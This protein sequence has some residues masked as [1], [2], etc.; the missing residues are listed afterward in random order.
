MLLKSK[1]VIIYVSVALFLSFGLAITGIAVLLHQG[2]NIHHFSWGS[3][4]FEDCHIVWDNKLRV[5]IDSLVISP[6]EIENSSSSKALDYR[7]YMR[8]GRYVGYFFSEIHVR[9]IKYRESSGVFDYTGWS[10]GL[11]GSLHLSF[12]DITFDATILS[13]GDESIFEINKLSSKRFT[14]IITG[15]VRINN[16]GLAKGEVLCDIEGIPSLPLTIEADNSHLTFASNTSITLNSIG[17]IVEMFELSPKVSP[18]VL[19]YLKGSSYELTQLQGSLFWDNPG[20]FFDNLQAKVRV[21]D[22]EYTFAEGHEPVRTEYTDIA[23]QKSVLKIYPHNTHFYGQDCER[24]WL[25]IDFTKPT[26]PILT[27]YIDTQAIVNDDILNLL[28]NYGIA[29]PFKQLEGK[30]AV[31]LTFVM[32]LSPF[33]I[34]VTSTFKIDSGV[35]SYQGMKLTV[36]DSVVSLKNSEIAVDRMQVM[37]P[38]TFEAEVSGNVDLGKEHGDISVI[39][40]DSRFKAG[41]SEI[42]LHNDEGTMVYTYHIRPD[43][44]T[45]ESTASTWQLDTGVFRL[46]A[47]TAAFNPESGIVTLPPT[48]FRSKRLKGDIKI[49]GEINGKNRTGDLLLAISSFRQGD[50]QLAQP[51]W[52]L[53]VQIDKGV[54]IVTR[55]ESKWLVH[56]METSLSPV[57]ILYKNDEVT[58][59]NAHLIYGDLFAGSMHGNYMLKNRTG[60]FFLSD[61]KAENSILEPLLSGIDGFEVTVSVD[62]SGTDFEIPLLDVKIESGRDKSWQVTLNDLK[63]LVGQF[64][65]LERYYL[66]KGTVSLG[67][68]NGKKPYHFEGTITYPYSIFVVEGQPVNEYQF[69]GMIDDKELSAR[70]MDK[71]FVS[72]QDK[73]SITSDSIE[74]NVV[75][76]LRLLKNLSS[77]KSDS[78]KK[79][80]SKSKDLE[81]TAVNS[82]LYFRP[83]MR[84][85]ADKLL[86]RIL[87]RKIY[88]GLQHGGGEA[89]L[90]V[91]DG[92]LSLEGENLDDSFMEAMIAGAKFTGGKLSFSAS[93][94]LDNYEARFKIENT[95][96]NDYSVMSNVLAFVNT[97]PALIT[98]SVP[99]YNTKGME[100]DV[101]LLDLSYADSKYKVKTFDINGPE[102]SVRGSGN[103]SVAE[104]T[105]DLKL[106]LITQGRKDMSKIPLVGYVLVG[107]EKV[108]SIT[109]QV[110]GKLSDPDIR[111]SAFEEVVTLP[112]DIVGR[113]LMTPFKWIDDALSEKDSS[114]QTDAVNKDSDEQAAKE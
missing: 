62:E 43:G 112:F 49:S 34:D 101:A 28:N 83:E 65:F 86:L 77:K 20:S 9:H 52:K 21:R 99:E 57:E 33:D 41:E 97:I 32:N 11:P 96:L 2:I 87:D 64:P 12:S 67:S 37:Y 46:A 89:S 81:L 110:T 24:S 66:S 54:K 68:K 63:K 38:G 69:S 55:Q 19:E 8:K 106:N 102:L 94:D 75:E 93:G 60:S 47:F 42:V 103:A 16:E 14:S 61:L 35:F 104:D 26:K 85:L 53:R 100:I 30:T 50:L 70:V 78:P 29:L 73:I 17:P 31:D 98:F 7:S 80:P 76:L 27:V 23:F 3:V 45:I 18:W 88:M 105:I 107:D 113:V 82:S 74:Y 91:A 25:K 56:N 71:L 84:I 111:N 90:S 39:L 92:H 10:E 5:T 15:S 108:P 51:L 109:L 44:H 114:K 13:A 72:V 6:D 1:K 36:S 4:A 58:I 22:C 48:S 40:V 59:R 79:G 95:I